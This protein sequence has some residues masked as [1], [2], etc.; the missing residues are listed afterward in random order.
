[1]SKASVY[2]TKMYS[3]KSAVEITPIKHKTDAKSANLFDDPEK[4]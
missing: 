2:H 3:D 4:K 1:M